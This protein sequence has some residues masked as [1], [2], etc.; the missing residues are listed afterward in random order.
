MAGARRLAPGKQMLRA[1]P[2]LARYL[3]H[4]RARRKRLRDDP[5]LLRVA[6]PPPAANPDP[7]IHPTPRLRSVNY[8]VDHMCE[9][10]SSTGIASSRLRRAPQDGVK[11]SLTLVL[12]EKNLKWEGQFLDLQ[13]G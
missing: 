7:D 11:T 5:P 1:D 2:V 9:P 4:H 10:I 3:R 8:M 13:R 6:P 12:A